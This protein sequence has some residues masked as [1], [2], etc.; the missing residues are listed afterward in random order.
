MFSLASKILRKMT[1]QPVAILISCLILAVLCIYPIKHLRWELQL[2]DTLSSGKENAVNYAEVEKDFGGLGSLTVVLQSED[3]LR[4]YNAAKKLAL[5]LQN[6]SLV[7]FLD[8]ETDVEFY[9]QHSLLYIDEQDLDTIYSRVRDL[10]ERT[11]KA[12]N[13][14]FVDLEENPQAGDD[15]ILDKHLH[16]E[17]LEEKYIRKVRQSH[18]STDG[19]IRVVDIY[20]KHALSNLQASR[21]LRNKVESILD[22]EDEIQYYF[23][24]K[25]YNT[26]QTGRTLLPEAKFAGI[27]TA[28]CILLL[29]IIHFYKQPQLILVSALPAGLPI[30][31]T[32][33]LASL[34][35]GRINLFTLLLAIFLPG[36]ACQIII[37]FLN[38]YFIERENKLGPQLSIES[39]VLG[40]GPSTA[41]S[42]CI[43][44]GLFLTMFLVP[45]PGLH[46]LGLLGAL[47]CL[48][49]WGLSIL[50]CT[51]LLRI[52]QRKKPFAVNSFRLQREY[53]IKL[54][55]YSAVRIFIAAISFLSLA[56]LVYG[57]CNLKFFY[58]FNQMEIK[59][60]KN[61]ADSLIM[62]T[63]FPQFDPIIVKLPDQAAGDLLLEDFKDLKKR[64][65]IPSIDRVYTLAQFS[66]QNQVEKKDQLKKIQSLISR[67][68]VDK[69]DS[70]NLKNISRISR[71]LYRNDYDES[72]VPTDLRNKFS[73]NQGNAGAFAYI[74]SN[75]NPSN[76]LECRRLNKELQQFEGIENGTLKVAGIPVL[77]ATFLDKI[78]ANID[79]TL[80][81]GTALIWFILLMYY[82]R[83]SRAIFTLLPTV[84]AMGWLVFALR[85]LDIELT[86]YSS[87][88]FTILFG[89]SVD[90]SLQLWTA[91][92]QK[93]SGTA[94]TILQ[95]KFFT[96]SISQIASLIGTYGLLISSHP[97]LHSI[98]IIC[99]L[100]L[101]CID[102]SQFLIFPLIAGSLDNYRLRKQEKMK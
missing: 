40:I 43:L 55:S 49:N 35:Y 50:V 13:P 66:A 6:D 33:A 101:I 1:R 97:G 14:F 31:Y 100:G 3:S 84:F 42:T 62:Q 34:L 63:G 77:R 76:G 98:G 102:L 88:A 30:L 18:A 29:F 41:A 32:L 86:A 26:I 9:R 37:H 10:R 56:G 20:P 12:N 75:I 61:T 94:I 38:R 22:R 16:L 17:D 25:V 27:V 93:Q 91:Y 80:F 11:I 65:K 78:L 59:H 4:N 60:E 47:G 74:F 2:Q 53:S 67:D 82:N 96:V 5:K 21:L 44:A 85:I 69:L 70:T 45:V 99:L 54:F 7:H 81:A 87:M 68:F 64:G 46:E 48:M 8:Y 15:S 79:K 57:I 28:I 23:T 51:S 95:S 39:A 52:F 73:D 92:Y 19:K 90:G 71:I 89:I 24:G 58:D 36:Q 72:E 83:L